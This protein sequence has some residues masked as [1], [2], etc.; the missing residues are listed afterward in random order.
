MAQLKAKIES[1]NNS[2]HP[3]FPTII[4]REKQSKNNKDFTF[5]SYPKGLQYPI[6]NNAGL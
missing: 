5:Q 2:H 6:S 1:M 4:Q 3:K